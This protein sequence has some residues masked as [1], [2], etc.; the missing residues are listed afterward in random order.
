M[1]LLFRGLLLSLIFQ[2]SGWQMLDPN[3]SIYRGGWVRQLES[4]FSLEDCPSAT[5]GSRFGPPGLNIEMS[6]C[7]YRMAAPLCGVLA[8]G[9]NR[10]KFQL[11]YYNPPLM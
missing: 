8:I 5:G 9:R 4:G 6:P 1:Y 7:V 10:V 2:H 11:H 3:E